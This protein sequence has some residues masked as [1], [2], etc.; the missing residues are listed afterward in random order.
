MTSE[1]KVNVIK[2]AS[3]S[4]YIGESGTLAQ[5]RIEIRCC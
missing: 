2:K 1:I 3:G 4:S 5:M